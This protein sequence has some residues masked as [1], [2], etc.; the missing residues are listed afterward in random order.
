MKKRLLALVCLAALALGL[1]ACGE[2]KNSQ[3]STATA[4]NSKFAITKEPLELTIFMHYRNTFIYD[5]NFPIFQKAAEETNI[6]L[7]GVASKS[8]TDS[9]QAYQLMLSAKDLP[10]IIHGNRQN[11]L[12]LGPEGAL[13]P[14][15]ELID[16]YA[17]NIK[18]VL[19]QYPD[20]RRQIT[21]PDGNIYMV[22][23]LADPVDP[24]ASATMAYWIRQDWLDKLNLPIPQTWEEYYDVL[25]AFKEKDPNGNGQAD[26]IPFFA[27]DANE[28]IRVTQMLSGF[29]SS[30]FEEDGKVKYAPFDDRF[31]EGLVMARRWYDEGL[32]DKEIYT[33]GANARDILL[34]NN[35]GG[36]THS[37][38]ST[39]STYNDRMA[40]KVP[41][42]NLNIMLPPQD[43]NG[44]RWEEHR[45]Y[46][47]ECT[48]EG[49][50]ISNTNK[51]PEE[52]MK[53]FDFWF[54]DEGRRLTAYG[55]EGLHYQ[56]VDGE[57]QYLDEIVSGDIAVGLRLQKDGA[58]SP[59][60]ADNTAAVKYQND[61]C[62]NGIRMYVDNNV[63]TDNKFIRPTILPFTPDENKEFSTKLA[64]ASTYM[65]E[66]QQ[67]FILGGANP[68]T[69]F[70]EY[71]R[72]TGELGM[73]EVIELCQKKFDEY[74]AR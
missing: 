34:G 49:W 62:K 15:N 21:A 7:K 50:G 45:Y 64:A 9:N 11:A 59:T 2:P 57:P 40:E 30:W 26:E 36:S 6:H 67:K 70:D 37:W 68:E 38:I 66:M 41:G 48:T 61:L 20:Y 25:K 74:Q 73:T 35:T 10:D 1:T 4:G 51:S 3:T 32:V 8:M 27:S 69:D 60:M 63:Y 46:P 28:F 56:M 5:E 54:S 42:F 43:V 23:G 13:I 29:R 16:K 52:T 14:L 19:N 72:K 58:L 44:K 33:R 47:A 71:L 17:P 31:K 22:A 39:M 18:K 65:T 12:T 24:Y 53:Y 55:V